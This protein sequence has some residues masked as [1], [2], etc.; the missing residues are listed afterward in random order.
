M[1]ALTGRGIL[2]PNYF[3]ASF[4]TPITQ[5]SLQT[6]MYPSSNGMTLF[7]SIIPDSV[8]TMA[9][10]LAKRGWNTSALHTA[11]EYTRDPGTKESFSRGFGQYK[12]LEQRGLSDP[13]VEYVQ[14]E[15]EAL[16]KKQFF[17]WFTV[18]SVHF[19]YGNDAKDIFTDPTYTGVLKGQLLRWELMTHIYKGA[20]YSSGYSNSAS[21]YTSDI[22]FSKP[23]PKDSLLSSIRLSGKPVRLSDADIQ[24]IE[25]MYDNGIHHFDAFFQKLVD[26]LEKNNI[27]DKTIIIVTSE[28]GDDHNEHNYFAHHDIYDTLVHVPLIIY[29]PT[30]NSKK[31]IDAITSTVDVLPT[32]L[33][34]IGIP[35]PQQVQ[36]KSVVPVICGKGTDLKDEAAYIERIPLWEQV[37]YRGFNVEEKLRIIESI[38]DNNVN[39]DIAIRTRRWKY[40]LRRSNAILEKVSWWKNF[41]VTPPVLFDEELYD[42][43]KDPYEQHNVAKDNPEVVQQLKTKLLLWWDTTIFPTIKEGK[44]TIRIQEYF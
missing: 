40:I 15:I 42:M 9:Q 29:A 6:G 4:L 32:L 12:A 16:K 24:Y 27:M 23:D 44:K 10:L 13:T 31:T 17:L 37:V 41:P 36:G 34:M 22:D 26:T 18:G 20:I 11:P 30:V 2:F 25:D 28:H 21:Y 3:T 7:S 33:A 1:D 38:P 43:T 8:I 14:N 5:M 39:V 35:T 19:P